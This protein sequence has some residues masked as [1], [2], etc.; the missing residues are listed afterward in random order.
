MKATLQAPAACLGLQRSV[1]THV[2]KWKVH[3]PTQLQGLKWLPYMGSIACIQGV[4]ASPLKCQ[5]T[6]LVILA[7]NCRLQSPSS[8]LQY[9]R[10]LGSNEW[11]LWPNLDL[12]IP[13]SFTFQAVHASRYLEGEGHWFKFRLGCDFL[14]N[15]IHVCIYHIV[16][17]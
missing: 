13:T 3:G 7:G 4:F 6:K 1:P 10:C 14:S 11:R 9:K 8:P 17:L 16:P 5:I 2:N 15:Y 12:N